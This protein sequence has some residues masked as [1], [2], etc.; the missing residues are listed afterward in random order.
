MPSW[1]TG[2]HSCRQPATV[3]VVKQSLQGST[4]TWRGGEHKTHTTHHAREDSQGQKLLDP[5]QHSCQ[6]GGTD[7]TQHW[8][9]D[10]R[11][12]SSKA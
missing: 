9:K 4:D 12:H 6:L 7:T 1:L 5:S 8:S 10:F 11:A 3:I 2:Q